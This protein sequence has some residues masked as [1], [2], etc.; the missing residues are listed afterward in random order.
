MLNYLIHAKDYQNINMRQERSFNNSWRRLPGLSTRPTKSVGKR[1]STCKNG[2]AKNTQVNEYLN[3]CLIN[4]IMDNE[5][6][7]ICWK[8]ARAKNG[9]YLK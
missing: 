3:R 7:S 4:Q 1:R 9:L 6:S 8:H 5:V 2:R